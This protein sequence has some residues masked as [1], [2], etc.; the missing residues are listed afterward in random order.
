[1]CIIIFEDIN[2]VSRLRQNVFARG[3]PAQK[4]GTGTQPECNTWDGRAERGVTY[5]A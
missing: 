1:M 5:Q 3:P 2:I 4:T